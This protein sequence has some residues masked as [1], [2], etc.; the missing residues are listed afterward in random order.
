MKV[1]ITGGSGFVGSFLTKGLTEKNHEVTIL[2]R[3]IREGQ[4][5]PKGA[6]FLEGD[7]TKKGPWQEK[8]SEHDAV[9]NLAG[10]S[11][12]Q[13]WDKEVKQ[14]IFDSRIFTTNNVVEALANRKGKETHLLSTSAVGYYG[15]HGDEELNESD[16]SGDDFLSYVTSSWESAALKA[17]EYGARTILCRF[18]IV[19]GKNGGAIAKLLPIYKWYLGAPLGNGKQWFSWIYEQDLAKIF[20]FLLEHKEL[21]GPINCTAPNPVRNKEMT[22]ILGKVLQKPTF[23]PPVPVFVLKIMQGEFAT[24]LGKGQK[25]IPKKLLDSGYKFN[26]PTMKEALENLLK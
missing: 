19:L 7:P 24:V 16:H 13:S 8:V 4:T 26:F 18:G 22:K 3:K 23:L 21:E 20:L 15:F 14:Q 10:A 25:V 17:K 9:I 2:T 11:I 12:F 1:F 5:L 6:S